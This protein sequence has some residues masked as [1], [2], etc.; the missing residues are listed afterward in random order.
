[1]AAPLV[2]LGVVMVGAGLVLV[3]TGGVWGRG[4]TFFAG[5][6]VPPVLALATLASGAGLLRGPAVGRGPL[7]TLP[8]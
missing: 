6:A 8:R 2:A 5:V 4:S 1:G 7:G 3:A